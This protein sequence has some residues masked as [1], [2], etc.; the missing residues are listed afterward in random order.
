MQVLRSDPSNKDKRKHPIKLLLI[1]QSSR[2]VLLASSTVRSVL[3]AC[4]AV[5]ARRIEQA[6]AAATTTIDARSSYTGVSTRSYMQR[7][8]SRADRSRRFGLADE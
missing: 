7:T 5:H 8:W 4:S 2:V 1:D 6:A 3:C